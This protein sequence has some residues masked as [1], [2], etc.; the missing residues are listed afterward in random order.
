[1]VSARRLLLAVPLF[2]GCLAQRVDDA[3]PGTFACAEQND[4]E[5][6]EHCVLGFCEEAAGPRLEIR[7]PEAFDRLA[8]PD[9]PSLPIAIPIS[10]GGDNLELAEP[11]SSGGDDFGFGYIEVVVDGEVVAR[12]TNGNLVAGVVAEVE[13]A[14]VPGAHRISAVARTSSGARYDNIESR[15]TRIVWIDDG[16]PHVAFVD[17]WPGDGFSLQE[18]SAEVELAAINFTFVPFDVDVAG[19]HGHAHVHHDDPFPAC[20][21]DPDCDCCYVSV[22]APEQPLEGEHRTISSWLQLPPASAGDGT[23]SVILRD[24]SHAPLLDDTGAPVW[25][26]VAIERHDIPPIQHAADAGDEDADGG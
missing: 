2:A 12:V 23:L 9:D 17:P 3:P 7:H 13:L 15:G 8:M 10:I 11:H 26:T 1:M 16:R 6:G 18:T 20:A 21:S 25:D 4:C 19:P 5:D 14:A 22:V 24:N